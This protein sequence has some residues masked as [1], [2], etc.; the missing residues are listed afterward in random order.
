MASRDFGRLGGIEWV[1]RTGGALTTAER[2]RLIVPIL[3]GQ[4]RAI[5]GRGLDPEL[6]YVASLLH[7]VGLVEAV[8]GEDFTLRSG[9]AAA[10]II[11]A[12]R[13]PDAARLVCDAITAHT[14]PGV[15]VDID[16]FEAVYV[17][18]GATLDLGGL[19]LH[20]LP[21]TLVDDVLTRH[22]RVGLTRD[23]NDRIVAEAKAVPDGRFALLRRTG[24]PLAIEYAPLPEG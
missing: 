3:R 12:N 24:S 2:R 21:A 14:T 6:F 4:A 19:R 13:S 22:P 5:L 7:D 16:G 11:E 9:A 17:Q 10:P 18:A 1:E 8:T 20:H 15:S 23:I